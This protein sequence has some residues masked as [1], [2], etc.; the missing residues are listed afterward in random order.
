M[1][2]ASE[3]NKTEE[4]KAE[5]PATQGNI[6]KSPTSRTNFPIEGESRWIGTM[7]MLAF[8]TLAVLLIIGTGLKF[9]AHED[10]FMESQQ[11][12]MVCGGIV[13]LLVCEYFIF[14][15][16]VIPRQ[17]N[18]GRYVLEHDGVTFFNLSALGLGVSARPVKERIGKFMGVTTGKVKTKKGITRYA[19]FL[20]HKSDKGK[21]ININDF[22]SMQEASQFAT[23]LAQDLGLA[24][25]FR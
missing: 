16:I 7:R 3:S 11:L 10:S 25:A 5:T 2:E 1:S 19:V 22:N 9:L 6:P 13:F 15:K 4:L 8:V 24:V 20:V 18:Y 23:T 17:A 12:M 21:T 14:L